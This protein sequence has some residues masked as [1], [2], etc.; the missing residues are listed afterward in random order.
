MEARPIS[1]T[2][3]LEARPAIPAFAEGL[4]DLIR[5]N[6]DRLRRFLPAVA[7]IDSVE[8]ARSHLALVADRAARAEILEW[9]LFADGVL[10]GSV[11]LNRIELGNRK[12]SIGYLLD[13]A[14]QGRGIATLAVR[15]FLG[16]WFRELGM[17]RVELTCATNNVASM[18]VAERAGFVREGWLR[19]A[20]WLGASFVDHYVYGLLRSEY[21][22]KVAGG[23]D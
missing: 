20:E 10:C 16:Y 21:L 14:Y 5:R 2:A 11:R 18:R 22:S 13:A 19:Q 8:K 12:T 7:T 17:N 15:A 1:I 3:F 9:Y 23:G 4:A 6:V